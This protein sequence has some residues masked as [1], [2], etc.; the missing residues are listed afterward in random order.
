MRCV[1]CNKSLAQQL[2]EQMFTSERV[3]TEKV[4][5]SYAP[6]N[7]NKATIQEA[8]QIAKTMYSA[9]VNEMRG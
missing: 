3:F 2:G 5:E 7:T 6:E 9:Y 8:V 1:T 4:A